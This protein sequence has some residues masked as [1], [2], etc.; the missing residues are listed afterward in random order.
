MWCVVCG[1]G[2][3]FSLF[4]CVFVSLRLWGFGGLGVWFGLVWLISPCCRRRCCLWCAVCC[5]LC[6]VVCCGVLFALCSLLFALCSLLFALCPLPFALCPL[7]FALCPLPFALCPL[8]FAL[9][10]LP[11]ALC[12]LPF[13]AGCCWLLLWWWCCCCC[14]CCCRC[15][16]CCSCRCCCCLC[17]PLV[18]AP[19]ARGIAG[20]RCRLASFAHPDAC[21]STLPHDDCVA[22]MQID[23]SLH[24]LSRSVSWAVPPLSS[25][26]AVPS[27][28][29]QHQTSRGASGVPALPRCLAG[30]SFLVMFAGTFGLLPARSTLLSRAAGPPF[31]STSH[32]QLACPHSH[33]NR[34]FLSSVASSP[35]SLSQGAPPQ[36]E[37]SGLGLWPP[38]APAAPVDLSRW[39][40]PLDVWRP[41]PLHHFHRLV[42]GPLGQRSPFRRLVPVSQHMGCLFGLLEACFLLRCEQTNSIL[43]QAL[44]HAHHHIHRRSCSCCRPSLSRPP[45]IAPAW[46]FGSRWANSTHLWYSLKAACNVSFAWSTL[47]SV[48]A[49]SCFLLVKSVAACESAVFAA[50]SC[51]PTGRCLSCSACLRLVSSFRLQMMYVAASDGV[52]TAL[53]V[54]CSC[55]ISTADGTG[56]NLPSVSRYLWCLDD[57]GRDT[58]W[59]G[60]FLGE[61]IIQLPRVGWKLLAC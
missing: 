28:K 15:C 54:S 61:S 26:S 27:L 59:I 6:A 5:V 22:L 16:C 31:G 33:S 52:A 47:V 29:C 25:H 44:D 57:I 34:G 9:C 43:R 11:F 60:Y 40:L 1:G 35:S 48:A 50:S 24:V 20:V 36:A 46:S 17:S 49:S 39:A 32:F 30:S 56:R 18:V 53:S 7:P 58:A 51:L 2:F 23:S 3:F 12:P 41:K 55:C 45:Q 10:P 38:S 8:P 13:A 4:L 14:C 37:L 21:A 19:S 42:H